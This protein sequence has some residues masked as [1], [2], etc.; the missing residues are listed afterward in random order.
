M[1]TEVCFCEE[2]LDCGL[3]VDFEHK[4]RKMSVKMREKDPFRMLLENLKL[5]WE[6]NMTKP[7]NTKGLS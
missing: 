5:I 3:E 6:I 4:E 2:W 1:K 7:N